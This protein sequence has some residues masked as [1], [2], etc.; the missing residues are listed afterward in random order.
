[1]KKLVLAGAAIVI[2][3]PFCA[4]QAWATPA[5]QRTKALRILDKVERPHI[6]G[7]LPAAPGTFGMLAFVA[8]EDPDTGDISVCSGTVVSPQLVLTAGHC[9]VSLETGEADQPAG[10]AVVTGSLDWTSPAR[11]VSA[12]SR[13]IVDPS[14]DPA[15]GD[16]DAALLVLTSPTTAP[17]VPLATDPEDIA[18][19]QPGTPAQIAGWGLTLADTIPDQLQWGVS[20]V[21]S[22]AYCATEAAYAAMSLDAGRQMCAIDPPTYADGTCNGDSGGPLLAQRSDGTW[23]EIGITN[24]GAANCST[25]IPDFFARADAISAW[26]GGWIQG[27]NAPSAPSAPSAPPAPVGTPPPPVS[28]PPAPVPPIVSPKPLPGVYRGRTN[29]HWPITLRVAASR[30]ALSSLSFSFSLSCTRHRRVSYTMSPGHGHIT[31]RLKQDHGLGFDD[32]FSD[33]TGERYEVKGGFDS[34]GSAAGFIR[35]TWKSRR[36]GTCSSGLVTWGARDT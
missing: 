26:V 12:V 32:T 31:W 24:W 9:A 20:V 34:S 33:T 14:Y 4:T 28:P 13:T 15:T 17:A 7:G 10:Y 21:Q 19:L 1:M 25:G 35:T 29:Q 18:L 22:S 11:Q 27:L 8:Y 2:A 30:T 16:G 23:V 6:L 36:F 3:L 5:K